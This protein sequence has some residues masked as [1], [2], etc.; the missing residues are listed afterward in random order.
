MKADD[1][2]DDIEGNGQPTESEQEGYGDTEIEEIEKK[3]LKDQIN[4]IRQ[5]IDQYKNMDD[6]E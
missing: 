2:F 1:E 5:E 4:Q 3:R 6:D